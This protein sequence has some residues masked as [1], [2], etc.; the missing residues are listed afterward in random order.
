M[1]PRMVVKVSLLTC[2]SI[3]FGTFADARRLLTADG[4][5]TLCKFRQFDD[6]DLLTPDTMARAQLT[7]TERDT[8]NKLQRLPLLQKVRIGDLTEAFG[9]PTK[10][11]YPPGLP[12]K[13]NGTIYIWSTDHPNDCSMC[14]VKI[15]FIDDKLFSINFDVDNRFMI[16][17]LQTAR[18]S[19]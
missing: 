15:A 18:Q 6:C 2:I 14:G 5:F 19:N 10:I 9:I 13:S 11:L 17:W 8:V 7:S 1:I 12:G 4:Q 16:A 3:C